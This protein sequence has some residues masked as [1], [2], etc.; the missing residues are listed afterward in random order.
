[1]STNN[2]LNVRHSIGCILDRYLCQIYVLHLNEKMRQS[3]AYELMIAFCFRLWW[4]RWSLLH[5]FQKLRTRV[6]WLHRSCLFLGQCHRG[7]YVCCWFCGNGA[8]PDVGKHTFQIPFLGWVDEVFYPYDYHCSIPRV[9]IVGSWG[10]HYRSPS[11]WH[12]NYWIRHKCS[13]HRYS[14]HWHGLGGKGLLII[15]VVVVVIIIADSVVFRINI[16]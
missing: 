11:Q 3:N 10:T 8:S 15:L 12:T 1:M 2:T 13:S 4:A 7:R 9:P 6:R 16:K 14:Y 5:D